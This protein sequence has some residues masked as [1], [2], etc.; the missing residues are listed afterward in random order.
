MKWITSTD[1]K[2]WADT[3][4]AQGLLPELVVRLIRASATQ[5][6]KLRFPCGDA[7][8]LIGTYS[9]EEYNLAIECQRQIQECNQQIAKH[10][11]MTILDGITLLIDAFNGMN[12]R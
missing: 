1:I 7:V 12:R 11:T 8:Q 10:G 2:Q 3:R 6:N 4:D 9:Q 5:V